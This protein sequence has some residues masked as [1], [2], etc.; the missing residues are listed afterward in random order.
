MVFIL[1]IFIIIILLIIFILTAGNNMCGGKKNNIAMGGGK[2]RKKKKK[3]KKKKTKKKKGKGSSGSSAPSSSGPSGPSGNEDKTHIDQVINIYYDNTYEQFVSII[4]DW[5]SLLDS[6]FRNYKRIIQDFVKNNSNKTYITN[7]LISYPKNPTLI[8]I[9]V[10][11]PAPIPTVPKPVL[12]P[13]PVL[14]PISTVP[15]PISTVPTVSVSPNVELKV[16]DEVEAN[17]R[18]SDKWCSGKISKIIEGTTTA[19]GVSNPITYNIKYDNGE[20]YECQVAIDMIRLKQLKVGDKIEANYQGKSKWYPGKISNI[21]GNNTY[22]IDYDD[23]DNEENVL[24]KNIR[25]I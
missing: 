4:S 22:N 11:D 8:P 13:T 12:V 15:T 6:D 3:A 24:L 5:P 14:V 21:N 10:P 16:G 17:Y 20:D 9:P 2:K 7:K 19:W 18:E 1:A 25:K 23:G